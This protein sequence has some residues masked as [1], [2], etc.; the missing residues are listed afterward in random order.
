VLDTRAESSAGGSGGG[1][2]G[3]VTVSVG[4]S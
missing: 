3:R 4:F 1:A 2:Q